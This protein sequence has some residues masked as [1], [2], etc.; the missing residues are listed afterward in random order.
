MFEWEAGALVPAGCLR[1]NG[2]DSLK[3]GRGDEA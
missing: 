3:R 1:G 2:P